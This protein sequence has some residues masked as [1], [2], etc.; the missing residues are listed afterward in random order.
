MNKRELFTTPVAKPDAAI[1]AAVKRRW[2][3]LSKP[4]DGLGDFR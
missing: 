4:L 3:A 2:D 1:L